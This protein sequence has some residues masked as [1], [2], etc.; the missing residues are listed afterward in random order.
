MVPNGKV[1]RL[2]PRAVEGPAGVLFPH[3]PS[4]RGQVQAC[5]GAAPLTFA[6]SRLTPVSSRNGA[7]TKSDE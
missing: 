7:A 3:R 2:R 6:Q 4:Y 1:N 5:A